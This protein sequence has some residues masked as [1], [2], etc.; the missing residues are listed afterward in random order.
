MSQLPSLHNFKS[1]LI[2][3]P[4]SLGDIV[5]TLPAVKSLREA[6]PHLKLRWL[7]NT[8]WTPLIQGSPLVDEVIAFPRKR[9]RGWQ[10]LLR[11]WKW[12]SEWMLLP[13]EEPEIVL[14]FQGLLRSGIVSRWRGGG[15]V[16]GFSDAREGARYFYSHIVPVKAGTHAVDRY[17]EM[18]RAFGIQVDAKDVS[19]ELAEGSKPVGVDLYWPQSVV[20]HP[21]SRGEGKSLSDET[22]AALCASLAPR[23]VILVG[24]HQGAK[25][26]QASHVRDLSNQTS[27][28]ELVWI[29]RRAGWVISVDSGPMHIGAAINP[30]T[31]GIHTWSDPRKVGPYPSTADVWKAGRIAKRTDFSAEE[32]AMESGIT[33]A[34]AQAM[35]A[36]VRA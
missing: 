15:P 10:G 18:P 27:L 36:W 26:P 25:I 20:V 33:P 1:A 16:I 34:A 2:V 4:S 13:R 31:L 19:F 14:D 35:A 28:V 32:C 29:M 24:M 23:P 8:E 6:H 22:L 21:W 7:A 9:F 17:L 3:K 12:R 5:H 30:R 11:F